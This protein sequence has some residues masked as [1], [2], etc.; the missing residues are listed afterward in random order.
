MTPQ[1]GIAD[2]EFVRGLGSGSYGEFYL[3]VTPARLPI[4]DE[5]VAVKVLSGATSEESYRRAIKELKVFA[6]VRSPHLLRLFEAGHEG[7]HLYYAAQYHPLGSLA[8]PSRPMGRTEVLGAVADAA[9]AAHDLHEAGIAHRGIKPANILVT[10]GGGCLGDLGLAQTIN[11]GQTVT[12][13]GSLRGVEFIDPGVVRGDGA[14]R[15]SDIYALGTTLHRALSGAG[16]FGE[17]PD[18]DPVAALRRVLSGNPEISQT[19]DEHTA[20]IIRHCISDDPAERPGT[21]A[22]VATLID[23]LISEESR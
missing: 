8:A 5:Y 1:L 9:R 17:L 4:D 6:G 18:R 21:A 19:L 3:A 14:S 15:A 11:P 7:D 20:R 22:E 16:I 10:T 12:G 13:V 23:E 2:Y